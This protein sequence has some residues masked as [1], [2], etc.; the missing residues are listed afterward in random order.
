M[1]GIADPTGTARF[2]RCL[3]RAQ[4][5]HSTMW[6]LQRQSDARQPGHRPEDDALD[7]DPLRDGD[8]LCEVAGGTDRSR[9]ARCTGALRP[10]G[11]GAQSLSP[12][13]NAGIWE[14]IL[15]AL[16]QEDPPDVQ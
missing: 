14:Q 3:H 8:G 10:L 2:P 11:D 4:Q 15:E 5:A 6:F 12:R 13:R 7:R 16:C 9:L 1:P